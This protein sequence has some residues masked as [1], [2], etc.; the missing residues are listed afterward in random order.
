M[1]QGKK[2][3]NSLKF[4]TLMTMVDADNSKAAEISRMIAEVEMIGA[5][6]DASFPFFSN[7]GNRN[8]FWETLNTFAGGAN[9]F[10]FGGDVMVELMKSKDDP[11]LE[12]YFQPYPGGGS[13]SIVRGAP[14]GVQ[15][16]P[17]NPWVLST[18][19]VSGVELVRP[20]AA[21]V[22]FSYSEQAFLEAE[23]MVRGLAAGGK[24]EADLRLRAAITSAMSAYGIS[25]TEIDAFLL[26][27]IPDL[28]SLSDE[29]ARR[30][31]AEQ[32]WIDCIIRPVEGF[33]HWRRSE[34]PALPVPEGAATTSI[35]RRLPYPP[36]EITANTNAPEILPNPDVNLWFDQ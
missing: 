10:Y 7:S 2:V 1:T 19:N 36:D 20:D 11:R 6:D 26:T 13:D 34:I 29:D 18:S 28:T 12:V 9:F 32:L 24:A 15:S 31:I 3:A 14:A 30:T 16:F 33:T 4:R 27:S 17:T 8:P 5:G 21:D 25:Q 35:L 23:A 22:L